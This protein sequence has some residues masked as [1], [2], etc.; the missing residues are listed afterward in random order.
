VT[1]PSYKMTIKLC[2]SSGINKVQS[3]L[4][5]TLCCDKK[6]NNGEVWSNILDP[7]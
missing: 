7:F 2:E 4:P 6:A 1:C 3:S 5:S